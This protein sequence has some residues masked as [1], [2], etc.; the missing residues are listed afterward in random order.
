MVLFDG[1]Q[2]ILHLTM[3]TE[4]ALRLASTSYEG[5]VK[6]WDI[7]DD[8]N[9]YATLTSPTASTFLSTM[10]LSVSSSCHYCFF[11]LTG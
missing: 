8:G 7:W 3:S 6:L 2:S 1:P 9:M 11:P 10:D 5:V 4:G